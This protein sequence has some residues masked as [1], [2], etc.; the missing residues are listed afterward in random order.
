[1]GNFLHYGAFRRGLTRGNDD[2]DHAG[3]LDTL[4]K[5]K[6]HTHTHNTN[7]QQEADHKTLG[8][9]MLVYEHVIW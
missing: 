8:S 1:M 7:M 4:S 3:Q 5:A 6:T 2:Y 9:Q